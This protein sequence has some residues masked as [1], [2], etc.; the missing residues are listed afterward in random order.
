MDVI[1]EK[2]KVNY[3]HMPENEF[4]TANSKGDCGNYT[5]SEQGQGLFELCSFW[6]G[7][8]ANKC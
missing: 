8:L 6:C 7:L 5:I 2:I 4:D 3:P 1:S